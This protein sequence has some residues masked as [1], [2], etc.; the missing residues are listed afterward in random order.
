[1]P[2]TWAT[3]TPEQRRKLPPVCPEFM[4]ESKPP[5]DELTVL[6]AK[7]ENYLANRTLPGFQLDLRPLR[8]AV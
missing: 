5:S 8:R 6:Q 4:M 2:T 3:L 1:M 7:M